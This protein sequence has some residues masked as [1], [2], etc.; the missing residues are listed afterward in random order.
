MNNAKFMYFVCIFILLSSFFL[1]SC[2]QKKDRLTVSTMVIAID[3][4][5]DQNIATGGT[6]T[7]TAACRS[8]RESSLDIQPSWTVDSNL[9]T[10]SAAKGK[11]TTFTAGTTPGTCGIYATYNDITSS[12]TVTIGPAGGGGTAYTLLADAGASTELKDPGAGIFQ[13]FDGG[14][15]SP[16]A[17]PWL[18]GTVTALPGCPV[19]GTDCT[20]VTYTGGAAGHWGGFFLEFN[21]AKSLSA[22]S[23]LTFYTKGGA[24]GE[25]FKIKIKGGGTETTVAITSYITL[26]TSW[27]KVTIPFA[28]FGSVDFSSVTNA[29]VM[30]F[31]GNTPGTVYIDFIRYE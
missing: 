10:F 31:E 4:A 30:A 8:A 21:A 29:F 9:G 18:I 13:F 26:T 2:A 22:Y 7:L 17:A 16:D 19:D 24:G 1:S 14:D 12:V 23:R 27:Q 20:Q 5:A 28:D 6:L 11:T 25:T 15:G 3:P